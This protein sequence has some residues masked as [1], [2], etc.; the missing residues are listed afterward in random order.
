MLLSNL[1]GSYGV[2]IYFRV[3]EFS[4][5]KA[6]NDC[7]FPARSGYSQRKLYPVYNSGGKRMGFSACLLFSE[8]AVRQLLSLLCQEIYYCLP[9]RIAHLFPAL[10]FSIAIHPVNDL[11]PFFCRNWPGSGTAWHTEQ[12]Q[13]TLNASSSPRNGEFAGSPLNPF[14]TR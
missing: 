14:F 13:R 1:S 7:L 2:R 9:V 11:A 6:S 5:A 4:M 3:V 8:M 10:F 12:N